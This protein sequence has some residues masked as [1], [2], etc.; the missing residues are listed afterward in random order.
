MRRIL[1]FLAVAALAFGQK[2]EVTVAAAANLSDVFQKIGP[3]FEK[4]TGIHPVFS[5]ASTAQLSQQIEAG[6]PYDVFA[7]ADTSHVVALDQKRL[8]TAGTRKIY[9]VGIL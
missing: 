1:L 7:A 9:A 8:I 2:R 3:E 4:E 6:A 5:Y